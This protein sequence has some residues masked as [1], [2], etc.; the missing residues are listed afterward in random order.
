LQTIAG[1]A[2]LG[3]RALLIPWLYSILLIDFIDSFD[4]QFGGFHE[5]GG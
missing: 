5:D 4:E 1:R 3:N 2:I